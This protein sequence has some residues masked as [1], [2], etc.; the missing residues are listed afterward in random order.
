[1]GAAAK[2]A[3]RSQHK[4][5]TPRVGRPG[6]AFT[7]SKRLDRLRDLL[8]KE[9]SGLEISE[10]ATALRITERS[11]RRY[12]KVLGT[13][14]TLEPIPT[15]PGGPNKWRIKPVER[16]RAVLL[17][18]TQ[19]FALLSAKRVFDTWRGSALFEELDVLLSQ[20]RAVGGRAVRSGS[21]GEAVAD[22]HLDER[23]FF[24]P[25]PAR[26]FAA[27]GDDL[28]ALF[29]AVA[30]LL[31]LSLRIRRDPAERPERVTIHPYGLVAH[32]GS[33]FIV[34]PEVP[35]AERTERS[36]AGGVGGNAHDHDSG[37]D[38]IIIVPFERTSDLRPVEKNRFFLPAEFDLGAYLHGAFGVAKPV[39]ERVVIEFDA[40]VAEEVRAKKVH[41]AQKLFAS[42]DG[43][44][45]L[46]FPLANPDAVLAFVLSYGDAARVVEPAAFAAE[47]GRR[48]DRAARRYAPAAPATGASAEPASVS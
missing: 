22:V 4:P 26:S 6:G 2:P 31:P 27:R 33:L 36:K 41:P 14:T 40:R 47:V 21:I 1:V 3:G 42:P 18:R 30:M 34:G 8:E 39:R 28:D 38:E 7:Q 25:P 9:P 5:K 48:L 35:G 20:I 13:K 29:R 19:A 46:A 45:R 10:M 15:T 17:R 16:G 37:K 43:R 11:V 12:L 23:F 44:V 24:L 32:G